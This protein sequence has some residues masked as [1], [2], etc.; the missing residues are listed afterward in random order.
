M[1]GDGSI[2][3]NHWRYKNLQYRLVIKLKYCSENLYML[4]LIGSHIG[5]RV[6]IIEKNKFVQWVVDNRKQIQK[7]IEI[8]IKYPPL[9]SRLRAQLAFMLECF[10]R[11]KNNVEWYLNARK[12]KYLKTNVDQLRRGPFASIDRIYFNEWLSGFIE[13]EGCFSKR[14]FSNNHSF[15][16][17]QNDDKFI[18]DKIK[19]HF[20]ITNQVRKRNDRFWLIEV[21]KKSTLI[22]II[23]HCIEYPLLGEKKLSFSKFRDLFK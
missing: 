19:N 23:N 6:R 18:L 16:I 8:F 11:P 4:N 21:Y 2:Q 10:E 14:T 7:I 17:G 22:N 13:A 12:N 5:G 9:T 1:D 20:N 3:V 15:S